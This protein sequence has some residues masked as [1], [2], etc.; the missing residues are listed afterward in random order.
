MIKK[1][2]ISLLKPDMWVSDLN[3]DWI[4]HGPANREGRIPNEKMIEQIMKMGVKELYIDTD[5]GLDVNEGFR[6]FRGSNSD[7][8]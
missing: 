2:P 4:P 6:Y 1:I 5:K 7:W 8:L 3:V